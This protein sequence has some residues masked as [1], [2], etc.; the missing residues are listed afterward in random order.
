MAGISIAEG[1][2]NREMVAERVRL[3]SSSTTEDTKVHKGRIG[4][5]SFDPYVIRGDDAKPLIA[6]IAEGN[7]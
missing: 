4:S 3:L 6:E 7:R 5:E 1:G 2:R